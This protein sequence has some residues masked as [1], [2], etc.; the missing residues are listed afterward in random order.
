MS[1]GWNNNPTAH[2]FRYIFRRLLVHAASLHSVKGNVTVFVDLDH[3][4]N[5]PP[6]CENVVEA[7]P[8]T[9][10]RFSH[11]VV[12]YVAGWIARRI[13][14]SIQCEQCRLVVFSP[15]QATSLDDADAVLIRLFLPSKDLLHVCRVCE[16]VF[17]QQVSPLR[18]K[19]E[20]FQ[21]SFIQALRDDFPRLFLDEQ[22]HFASGLDG[23]DE[24]F[25]GLIR[26]IARQYFYSRKFHCVRI[27]ND[28]DFS[29]RTRF[30]AT[31]NIHFRCE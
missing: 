17:R 28:A 29:S 14:E 31:K 18:L 13:A 15:V 23:T 24:H 25:F 16:T 26:F 10:S 27:F 20:N 8:L 7:V 11:N 3:A 9:L 4:S 19:L 30:I 5:E 1:G 6:L 22:Q 12:A 21:R 2:Q